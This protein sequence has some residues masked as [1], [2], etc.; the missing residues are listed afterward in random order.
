MAKPL[1]KTVDTCVLSSIRSF[2]L[3]PHISAMYFVV[4]AQA[5]NNEL[6]LINN[7]L[8]HFGSFNRARTSCYFLKMSTLRATVRSQH[9]S[10]IFFC[11]K[12]NSDG[13]LNNGQHS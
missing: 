6:K 2:L 4:C 3:V 7:Y 13:I 12:S 9:Y 1:K 5:L 11:H 8:R 10:A